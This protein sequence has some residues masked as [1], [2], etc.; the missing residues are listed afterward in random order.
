MASLAA[1]CKSGTAPKAHVKSVRVL[2]CTNS[3][4]WSVVIDGLNYA[5]QQIN[6]SGRPSVVSMSL[7]GNSFNA[8]DDAVRNAHSMG[9]TVVVAAS[10]DRNDAC[11]YSPARSPYAITVGGTAHNRYGDRL[12]VGTNF[13]SC[14]DVFA[15]GENIP[16][17]GYP[18]IDC[19]RLRSGTSMAAPIVS[20]VVAIMLQ[21]QPRLTPNQVKDSI[22]RNSLANAIANFTDI[23]VASL[24][25]S[26]PNR[27]VQVTGK[28]N[29]CNHS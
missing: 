22:I 18:C 9:V 28:D 14:V 21:R 20:G 1:G 11:N 16:A 24:R 6:A 10:N 7:S 23:P 12:Y 19:S 2:E 4:P 26:T 27:L 15:P 8:M 17:A 3:G 29:T 25:A 5:V 13:G